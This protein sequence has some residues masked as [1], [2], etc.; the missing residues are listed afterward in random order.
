LKLSAISLPAMQ[1][2]SGA[3][4]VVQAELSSFRR[5]PADWRV[6]PAVL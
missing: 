1:N 6:Q 5:E 4:T 2:L 3:V